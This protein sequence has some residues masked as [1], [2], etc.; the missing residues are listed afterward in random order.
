MLVGAI[1]G[2]GAVAIGWRG[3]HRFR[4]IFERT[5]H[6]TPSSNPAPIA[7]GAPT[8]TSNVVAET[9]FAQGRKAP[10]QDWGWAPHDDVPGGPARVDMS[11]W[12]G[13][14]L[15]QPGLN[16]HFS[17]LGSAT[18]PPSSTATS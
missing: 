12:G 9:L 6:S 10:W 2:L 1:V 17:G 16:A 8:P 7:V 3:R 4:G 13:W 15:V 14:Q 5:A 18:N 11:N